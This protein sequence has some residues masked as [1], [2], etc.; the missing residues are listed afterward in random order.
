MSQIV[1]TIPLFVNNLNRLKQDFHWQII[2]PHFTSW[3][4]QEVVPPNDPVA[5]MIINLP[6]LGEPVVLN[7]RACNA[8]SVCAYYEYPTPIDVSMPANLTV[9]DIR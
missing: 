1:P 6:Y 8:Y 9:G 4:F 2:T 7:V 5:Q 3:Y